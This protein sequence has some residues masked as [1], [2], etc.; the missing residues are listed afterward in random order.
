MTPGPETVPERPLLKPWYRTAA[1]GETLVLEYGG[2]TVTFEGRAATL[3]LPALLPLLD[4][5]RTRDEIVAVVGE[6]VAPAV[7]KALSMLTEHD[8]LTDGPGLD[9]ELPRPVADA[10]A[11]LSA[12]VRP[13]LSPSAA[14]ETLASSRVV[15]LGSSL[16]ASEVGLQLSLSGVGSV[17]PGVFSEPV[18]DDASLVVAAPGG[19]ELQELLT[20]NRFALDR[21]LPWLPLLPFDGTF[22]AIGP[23]FVP[24]ETCCYE[25]L[26]ERRAVLSDYALEFRSLHEQPAYRPMSPP[27]TAVVAGLGATIALRWLAARD[28]FLPG[29]LHAL[30]QGVSLGLTRHIVYRVPRCPACFE[31]RHPA[32]PLPWTDDLVPA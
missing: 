28:P 1:M 17:E 5:S 21:G 19:G 23:L 32:A 22:A 8:L 18:A 20:R 16:V 7:D 25:C 15:V 6:P 4:G 12:T 24:P 30:E 31:L 13:D 14:Q 10:V 3:L 9:A 11:F 29:V 2:S 27:F 26:L